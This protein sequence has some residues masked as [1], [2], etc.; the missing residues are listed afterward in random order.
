MLIGNRKF[1]HFINILTHTPRGT[2]HV[3]YL[4]EIESKC[5]VKVSDTILNHQL[6]L[7]LK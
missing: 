2:K 6:P 3:E 5:G 4:I 7:K 1:N